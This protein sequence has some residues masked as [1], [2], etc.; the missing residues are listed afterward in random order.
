[1]K[2]LLSLLV[3]GMFLTGCGAMATQSEFWQHETMYKSWDH[4]KF[5][6]VGYRN[7]TDKTGEKSVEQGWWGIDVPY[8]PAK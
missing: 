4:T 1:M 3:L 2:K 7:P 8:I 5:S 6:L